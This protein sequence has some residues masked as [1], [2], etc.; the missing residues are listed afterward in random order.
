ME[1]K[2]YGLDEQTYDLAVDMLNS[3]GVRFKT[4]THKEEG[5]ILPFFM[6][7]D[8]EIES[9]D[10]I[11]NVEPEFFDYLK[12]ELNQKKYEALQLESNRKS[13]EA[14]YRKKDE[15]NKPFTFDR[16][17]KEDAVKFLSPR[18]VVKK[19][20]IDRL[21]GAVQ[22]EDKIAFNVDDSFFKNIIKSIKEEDDEEEGIPFDELDEDVQKALK[23]KIPE[24]VLRS[25]ICKIIKDDDCTYRVKIVEE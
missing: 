9:Y 12:K 22:G 4:E 23:M 5:P 3:Y 17:E 1:F 8:C 25:D 19:R 6:C 18:D 16:S 11:V 14:L 20:I 2:F 13:L 7:A 15:D 21:K 10:I 24:T